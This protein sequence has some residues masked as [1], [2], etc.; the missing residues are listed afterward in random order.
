MIPPNPP[1]ALP[2]FSHPPHRLLSEPL[3]APLSRVPPKSGAAGW[4]RP[5]CQPACPNG[6]QHIKTYHTSQGCGMGISLSETHSGARD[7]GWV[8]ACF[9][10]GFLATEPAKGMGWSQRHCSW[11]VPSR[12]AGTSVVTTSG[13][14]QGVAW[15]SKC[16]IPQITIHNSSDSA[17]TIMIVFPG[18]PRV[19]LATAALKNNGLVDHPICQEVPKQTALLPGAQ[20]VP[21]LLQLMQVL[22][23]EEPFHSKKKLEKLIQTENITSYVCHIYVYIYTTH[24]HTHTHMCIFIYYLLIY[25]F[26]HSLV[27]FLLVHKI[28]MHLL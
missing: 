25:L 15:C 20:V 9:V 24:A 6:C 26:I 8:P 11:P 3:H 16:Q 27:Y 12:V 2:G 7:S 19:F 1:L 10:R 21:G 23:A 5:R 28:C 13:S 17:P 14:K 18:L 22:S 4:N